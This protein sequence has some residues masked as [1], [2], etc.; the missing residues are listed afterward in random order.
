MSHY[1][2]LEGS[3]C[4]LSTDVSHADNATHCSRALCIQHLLTVSIHTAP[5]GTILSGIYQ[6]VQGRI[7]GWPYIS[8]SKAHA[9][10]LLLL[11][12]IPYLYLE[13]G[14]K[15]DAL[16]LDPPVHL[17]VLGLSGTME[18]YKPYVSTQWQE[19][20]STLPACCFLRQP[21]LS[22]IHLSQ[23]L[24]VQFCP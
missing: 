20:K 3:V 2:L 7:G 1:K 6:E 17:L 4:V 14:S 16:E 13:A 15:F 21:W 8:N 22:Q 24:W 5:V 9:V 18:A 12:L 23:N 11:C 19:N 10:H